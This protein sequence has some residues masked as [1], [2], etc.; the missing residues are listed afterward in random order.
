MGCYTLLPLTGTSSPKLKII[1][2]MRI[3][4]E[5]IVSR[6]K[7]LRKTNLILKS[8]TPQGKKENEKFRF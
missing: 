8:L 3:Q 6:G 1:L 5:T 7:H 4:T 2:R